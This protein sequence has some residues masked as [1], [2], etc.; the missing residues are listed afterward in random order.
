VE[1]TRVTSSLIRSVGYDA[2]A[3]VLEVELLEGQVYRY[4][5]VSAFIYEG[6]LASKSK[7]AF[8]NKRIASRFP[9][10]QL[11]APSP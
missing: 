5:D 11:R 6:L 2:A 8:F 1:R 3:R 9:F 10:E 4:R 7:G